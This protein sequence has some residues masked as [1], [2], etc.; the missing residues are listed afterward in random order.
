MEKM[1]IRMDLQ[2]MRKGDM[3]L[4]SKKA[5]TQITIIYPWIYPF[6]SVTLVEHQKQGCL[7]ECR[8]VEQL[9]IYNPR[10]WH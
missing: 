3:L 10:F 6:C 9:N 7:M 4:E 2:L 8:C 1:E 5:V